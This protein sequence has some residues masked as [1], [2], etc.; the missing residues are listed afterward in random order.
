MNTKQENVSGMELSAAIRARRS[1]KHYDPDH[2]LTDHELRDLLSAAALAP[3]SFNMQNRHF[4]AV[5]DK[6]RKNQLQKAAWG[7]EQVRDA[8]VVIVIAGDLKSHLRGD[9]Y[10]RNAPAPVREQLEPMIASFYNDKDALL[11]DEACRSVGLAA[12]NL[13]LTAK[14]LGFDSCPLI[15]FDPTQVSQVIGLD[16]DHPPLMLVVVGKGTKP[17]SDRLGLLNLEELVSVDVFG[18]HSITGEID[19]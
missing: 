12:M 8:S 3:T 9:R 11:R 4:I 15:G 2:K 5:V 18:N 17:A 6:E 10:L 1:V 16:E 14:S 19:A 13:M 7:Q